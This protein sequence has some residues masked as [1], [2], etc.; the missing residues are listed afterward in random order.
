[1]A[2]ISFAPIL[3]EKGAK[4]ITPLKALLIDILPEEIAN[5]TAVLTKKLRK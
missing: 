3:I 2:L 1:M 4:E 5:I